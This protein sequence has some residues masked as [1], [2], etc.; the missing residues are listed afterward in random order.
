MAKTIDLEINFVP[1]FENYVKYAAFTKL[2]NQNVSLPYKHVTNLERD[3]VLEV[4]SYGF[5]KNETK[6][7][8]A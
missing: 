4:V 5:G 6:V 3:S 1:L 8:S 2:V 7:I